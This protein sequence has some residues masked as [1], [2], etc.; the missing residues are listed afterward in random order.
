MLLSLLGVSLEVNTE[1][2]TKYPTCDK[3]RVCF[4]EGEGDMLCVLKLIL[5]YVEV[6]V[7]GPPMQHAGNAAAHDHDTVA[8]HLLLQ[9]CLVYRCFPRRI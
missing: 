2:V 4:G 1:Q 9:L 8:D 3:T 5:Y 6:Q 7:H